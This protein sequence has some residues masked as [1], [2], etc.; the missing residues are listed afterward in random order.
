NKDRQWTPDEQFRLLNIFFK[1][2]AKES[3]LTPREE[4]E[5]SAKIKNCEARA[6]KIKAL[7]NEI[8]N[9]TDTGNGKTKGRDKGNGK[10]GNHPKPQLNS[11]KAQ[12]HKYQN[13][14]S[15]ELKQVERLNT[16][17]KVYSERA[18]RLRERFI[19][20]N[21]KLVVS[22]AKKHVNRGLP[23]LDLIQ[24]GSIGLI[25]AL[26]KF[27]HTLGYRF[28]TYASWWINQTIV[29]ALQEKTR[30]IKIPVYIFEQSGKVHRAIS[31]LHKELDR[32]PL[33]DE[34]A[35]EAGVSL[36]VVEQILEGKNDVLSLD[37]A[38]NEGEQ[39]YSEEKLTLFEL[40][41]DDNSFT[42]DFAIAKSTSKQ[43]IREVLSLLT[44]REEE[45]IR[46]RFG[47][48]HTN[49]YTLDEIGRKFDLT[50]ERIR[51]LEKGA[52]KKLASSE[53]REILKSF[54]D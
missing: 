34:I 52:L 35:E 5:I 51:Q 36:E 7:I 33:P 20:A 49:P 1:D 15:K 10:N 24:E 45:I 3:L 17:M 40:I 23:L 32:K 44:P 19:K 13:G 11:K 6:K 54:L 12:H 26:E 42:P 25:R 8:S 48:E 27:D 22:I 47:I 39:N 53:T 38:I 28:S 37:S 46:M 21:L 2:M 50:R 31:K 41:S 4:I 16:L 18:D 43:K 9:G 30:T 14:M 29:R